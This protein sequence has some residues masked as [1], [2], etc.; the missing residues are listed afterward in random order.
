MN[1]NIKQ[2]FVVKLDEALLTSGV[3]SD[4]AEGQVGIFRN[5]GAAV[6][7]APSPAASPYIF[8]AQGTG[9][10]TVPSFKSSHIFVNRV[11]AWRGV[12][13]DTTSQEQITYVGWDEINQTLSPDIHCERSYTVII[14]IFEHY[15]QSVYWPALQDGVVVKAPCCDDCGTNCDSLDCSAIFQEFAD[16]INANPRLSPYVTATAVNT[17]TAGSAATTKFGLV[18]PDPGTSLGTVTDITYA[19][20]AAGL[21][22]GTNTGVASTSGGAGTGATFDVVV[23]GGG[24][25]TSVAINAAGTGYEI[26]EVLTIAGTALTGGATPADDIVVT[27]TETTGAEGDLIA[28]IRDF[29]VDQVDDAEADIVYSADVDSSDSD[30]NSTGNVMIEMTP[31]AGVVL[32]DIE[33]WENI[34][35]VDITVPSE[36]AVYVC[37]LKLVGVTPAGLTAVDCIPDSVGYIAN[38]TRFKVFAGEAPQ[39]SQDLDMED[40]CN[41]WEIKNTQD[42]KY[43]IG[44]GVAIAEMERHYAGYNQ[45][46]VSNHRYWIPYYNGDFITFADSSLTYDIYEVEYIDPSPTGFEHKT[47]DAMA[48]MIAVPET[49]TAWKTAFETVMNTYLAN[50]PSYQAAV[51]L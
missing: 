45:P 40:F 49:M 28:A 42:V 24:T 31:S 10:N 3:T 30:A 32:A 14:R 23:G 51:T 39:S 1:H 47:D 9:D 43:P 48:V 38:K 25:V 37:G 29:Y 33:P 2:M 15:L 22:P 17:L 6:I 44:E 18:V 13:A 12:S 36:D 46:G 11:T 41:L 4:L 34:N 21:T 20:S 5:T 16:K 35:W 7:A 50:S 26:G 27:V 8:I 19:T